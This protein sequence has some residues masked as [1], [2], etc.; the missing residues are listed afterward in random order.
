MYRNRRYR[1]AR[2]VSTPL[3]PKWVTNVSVLILGLFVAGLVAVLLLATIQ[4][5]PF[6]FVN[7]LG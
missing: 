5:M 7:I 6:G 3:G 2:R 4:S 1:Q